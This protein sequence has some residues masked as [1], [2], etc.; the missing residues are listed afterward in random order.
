MIKN[1]RET[2]TWNNQEDR[3]LDMTI[4]IYQI[5]KMFIFSRI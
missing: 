4:N 2:I 5:I 1:E 3:Q